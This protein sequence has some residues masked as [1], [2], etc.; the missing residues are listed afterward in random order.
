[1]EFT[2]EA[3][4]DGACRNNGYPGAVGGAGVYVPESGYVGSQSLSQ[5]LPQ[6][7]QPTNQRA[8]LTAIFLGLQAAHQKQ[9]NLYL[10]PDFSQT[11][12]RIAPRFV[13]TVY[14]D[15]QYSAQCLESWVY[16]WANNGWKKFD[17]QDV[18]NKDLVEKVH[19]LRLEIERH[20]PNGG[21]VKFV[22]VRRAQ[23]E[24]NKIAD[25]LA[26]EGCDKAES[27]R[28]LELSQYG[29]YRMN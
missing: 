27:L 18:L 20:R 23:N 19:N 15:S 4:T 12:D 24:F 5:P 21:W 16:T 13:L 9:L 29:N 17:G 7:P 6:Y 2:L 26:N 14:T 8:E 11:G 1:M 25:Q 28:E 3:W 10:E 22:W